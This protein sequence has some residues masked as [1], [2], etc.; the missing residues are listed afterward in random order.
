MDIKDFEGYQVSNYGRVKSLERYVYN[1]R[2]GKQHIKEKILKVFKDKGGYLKCALCKSGKCKMY[3]IHRLV[4]EAF[5]SNP[6][7]LPCVNH[8]D[9][10][11]ENN[12][13]DNLEWCTIEYNNKYGTGN[14]RRGKSNIGTH[15]NHQSLSKSVAQYS[16][17]GNLIKIWPS[18]KEIQ[19]ELGY[20]HQ[21]INLCCK[22]G[23]YRK[24]KWI[25]FNKY[26][27]FIWKYAD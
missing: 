1:S 21:N 10:N 3:F 23:F 7:N 17:D 26:K 8:K 20:K 6:D 2:Y 24:G 5:I 27:D 9:E 18:A 22:G 12:Y 25:N 14:R 13:V 4:A 19:R 15:I 11:K 16:L